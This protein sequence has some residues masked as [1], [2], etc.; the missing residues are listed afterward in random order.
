MENTEHLA[1]H[2]PPTK[3]KRVVIVGGGFGGIKLAHKL[4]NKLFQIV[5]FDRHNYHTFQPLLYQV[6][7]AGL[8]PDSIAGPL[9]KIIDDNEDFYFRLSKVERI[10]PGKNLIHTLIGELYYDYLVLANGS[11]TNYFGNQEILKYAFPLKQLPQALDLR[12]HLLQTFERAVM[13]KDSKELQGLMTFVIVGGGPTGVE[14]AGALSELRKHV[15]PNDY[16]E[17]DFSQ[18][19]IYLVEGLTRVLSGMSEKSGH[20]AESYL[21][22]FGVEVQKLKR[23]KTYDGK[24]VVFEDGSELYAHTLIWAAGVKGNIIEGL[25]DGSIYRDRIIVDEHL[26]VKNYQNIF[27]I[28]DIAFLQTE[29]NPSGLPMLAPVAIQQGELVAKNLNNIIKGK[30]I[31]GFQYKDKGSMATIGRNRAVV[32]LPKGIHFAG[33]FAWFVWM[34]VHLFSI[35]GFRNKIVVFSNWLFN[36]F[37]YDRSTRLIIRPFDRTEKI[38][39]D[40]AM[41]T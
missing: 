12:S 19:K 35:I 34:F 39:K 25:K 29:E 10:E 32:D 1:I 21:R 7:T 23:V 31:K 22:N 8:E 11:K 33:L 4:D 30:K 18:M 41:N 5:M 38:K 27:A 20:K 17:L 2:I 36:Y 26:K 3:K 13:T 9:R 6:A 28:G 40:E 37:T 14:V 24:K 16:P 15:L